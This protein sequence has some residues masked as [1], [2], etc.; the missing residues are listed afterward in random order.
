MKY[1]TDEYKRAMV[2]W[3]RKNPTKTEKDFYV[4]N[5]YWQN[6]GRYDWYKR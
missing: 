2:E 3:L 6:C 4:L 1:G 5:R